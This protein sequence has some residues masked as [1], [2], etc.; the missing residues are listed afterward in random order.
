MK[1]LTSTKCICGGTIKETTYH[2]DMDGV[3]HC[4]KCKKCYP[5]YIEENLNKKDKAK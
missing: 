4:D 5:R 2:D 1:D 3:L